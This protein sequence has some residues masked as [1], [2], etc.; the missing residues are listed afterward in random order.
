[1]KAGWR[2]WEEV[3][4][5]V[6]NRDKWKDSVKALIM[7][8]N[9]HEEDRCRWRWNIPHWIGFQCERDCKKEEMQGAVEG[10]GLNGHVKID[11][12]QRNKNMERDEDYSLSSCW[13]KKYNV[14]SLSRFAKL[15][16]SSCSEYLNHILT[17]IIACYRLLTIVIDFCDR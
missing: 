6:G 11:Y 8:H 10:I 16:P 14:L 2:S 9:W 17:K 5:V 15:I 12:N 1:M 4:T 7:C 13:T 3:K